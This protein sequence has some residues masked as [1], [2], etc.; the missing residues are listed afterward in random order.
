M[1]EAYKISYPFSLWFVLV[2]F[3][4]LPNPPHS[5]CPVNVCKYNSELSRKGRNTKTDLAWQ[6]GLQCCGLCNLWWWATSV[7]LNLTSPSGGGSGQRWL[8][9]ALKG[10][11]RVANT[12]LDWFLH[13]SPLIPSLSFPTELRKG[14]REKKQLPHG[15]LCVPARTVTWDSSSTAEGAM[16]GC[17]F[18]DRFQQIVAGPACALSHFETWSQKCSGATNTAY[19]LLSASTQYRQFFQ[20][21]SLGEKKILLKTPYVCVQ[22]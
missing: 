13:S 10:M 5:G 7:P 2:Y 4:A 19:L 17:F 3:A 12:L 14:V 6:H 21:L 20:N 9:Q 22:R 15:N 16:W 11:V 18:R 1:R 8:Q